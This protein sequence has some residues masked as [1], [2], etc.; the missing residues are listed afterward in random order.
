M[1]ELEINDLGM[2]FEGVA[3][4]D[5]KV[6]FVPGAIDGEKIKAETVQDKDKFCNAKL[7]EIKVASNDRVEPFC[8]YYSTC[9][10]CDIQHM[11][12]QKQ[13]DAK[14]KLVQQTI[15]KVAGIQLEVLPT[16]SSNKVY[17]YRNKGAFPVSDSTVG[18]FKRSSHEIVD[19]SQ[20]FLMDNNIT[21]AMKVVKEFVKQKKFKGYD[22]ISHKGDIKFCV[23]RSVNNQTIVCIV[24]TKNI[25]GL[26]DLYKMLSQE[27]SNV[28]LYVNINTQK[29]STILSDNY[30]YIAGLNKIEL[31]EFGI[32]YK[33][34]IASFLQVNSDI[35]QKLYSR[36]LDCVKGDIVIDA[37]A[38][39]GLLS[40]IISK[41]AK[42]V[43]SIEIVPQATK[44]CKQL[45]KDNNITNVEALNGDCTKLVPN[46]AKKLNNFSIILDPAHSGCK[47]DV[48]EVAKSAEKIVYISCNPIALSKDLKELVKSHEIE[49]IEPYDMFPQTKHVETFVVLNKKS[50]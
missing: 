38:G 10:G 39:A 12:Y 14:R 11:N 48:I 1:I 3:R 42:K 17:Y 8:P 9:G 2:N 30:V 15:N 16:V 37:Y 46:L 29:N 19:I 27:L 45:L 26:E 31:E 50:R 24:A 35:K 49:F 4:L 7:K 44:C 41:T 22:F 47:S 36:V 6:Y 25:S 33:I 43:Y 18:M 21:I 40:A 23:V 20:C 32:K 34:D 28:G 5:G 13:L